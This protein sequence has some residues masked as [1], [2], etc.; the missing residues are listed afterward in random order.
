MR[1]ALIIPA[2]GRG[3]RLGAGRPKAFV[4]F[5]GDSLLGHALGNALASGV[6]DVVGI[7][8]PPSI[9]QRDLYVDLMSR[10]SAGQV[11][12]R[13]RKPAELVLTI[14]GTTRRESVS[15]VLA[16]L[17]G[18]VDAVLVHD[19]ARCLTPPDVFSAVAAALAAGADAVVPAL[20]VADTIKEVSGDVVTRTLDRVSLRAVQTPQGFGK[21]VL[22]RAHAEV[23]GDVSDDAGMVEQLGLK[24][25]VVPG[26]PEAFKITDPIDLM[27]AEAVLAGRASRVR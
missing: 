13:R 3:E 27:L 18:E 25:H 17:P 5:A 16:T 10:I 1:I 4:E 2:A 22:V 19:A 21:D 6:I 12:G 8:H 11:S 23:A 24:V 26:H 20:P 14:G 9:D 15:A 7:A